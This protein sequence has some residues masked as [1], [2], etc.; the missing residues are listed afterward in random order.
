MPIPSS[1]GARCCACSSPAR[2]CWPLDQVGL[3]TGCFAPSKMQGLKCGIR[4]RTFSAKVFRKVCP[5]RSS[6]ETLSRPALNAH[7]L[8]I[9]REQMK[10]LNPVVL[11]IPVQVM[12]HFLR[13]QE[14]A[15]V[16]LH[17]KPVL[18]HVAVPVGLWMLAAKHKPV[19]SLMKHP[20]SLP[21]IICRTALCSRQEIPKAAIVFRPALH[22]ARLTLTARR[23]IERSLTNQAVTIR[24]A[25]RFLLHCVTRIYHGARSAAR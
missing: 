5:S 14:S 15:K 7:V 13:M 8:S 17:H 20:P 18:A 4:L 6:S 3:T 24:F 2:T 10:I 11:R 9:R 1:Y 19:F 25:I 23:T 16:P 12:N 22:R 21:A